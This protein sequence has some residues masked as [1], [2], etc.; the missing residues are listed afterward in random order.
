MAWPD[1]PPTDRLKVGLARLTTRLAGSAA[2]S[3]LY[4]RGPDEVRVRATLGSKLL[5]VEDLD[6]G[7]RHEWT[8]MDFCVPA[9]DLV[10]CG[11]R[12]TPDRGDELTV[13]LEDGS[14]ERY[15]VF[16]YNGEPAWRWS[17]PHRS[18]VRIHAKLVG[19]DRIC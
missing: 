17:D 4:R 18:M 8:D 1:D 2:Q 11:E 5:R 7:V 14:E 3:V 12:V 19:S 16:P 9:V 13:T 6:G 10:L 15:E